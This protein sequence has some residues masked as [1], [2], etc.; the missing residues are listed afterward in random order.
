MAYMEDFDATKLNDHNRWYKY[1]FLITETGYKVIKVN[2]KWEGGS[3]IVQKVD[4]KEKEDND[5]SALHRT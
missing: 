4:L 1:K 3:L 5:G 2:E